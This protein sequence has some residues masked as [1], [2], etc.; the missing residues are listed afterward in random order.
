M[1]AVMIA[2]RIGRRWRPRFVGREDDLA[3]MR[4]GSRGID[5]DMARDR[6]E[7]CLRAAR[8]VVVENPSWVPTVKWRS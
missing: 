6:A 1:D 5:P 8:D 7:Q 4:P 2:Q 3:A